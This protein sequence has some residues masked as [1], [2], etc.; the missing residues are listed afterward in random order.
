MTLPNTSNVYERNISLRTS[1][2]M[3]W[4]WFSIAMIFWAADQAVKYAVT[5]RMQLYDSIPIVPGFNWIY[6]LNPGAAFSFLA[7]AG[8]WQRYFFTA[9]AVVVSV[10]LMFML[11]R[12]VASRLE[13]L[14]YALL[15]AG[16]LGNGSDRIRIG[17]VVDYLDVY[18][19]TWHW[20]AFNLA[21]ICVSTAAAMLIASAFWQSRQL[22]PVRSSDHAN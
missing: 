10:V 16:A 6:V 12:G 19:R 13:A 15:I 2:P 7:N 4:P 14:A 22:Q 21:D 3:R 9:I 8:G 5:Q 17:A 1:P 11:W 20:P 18:W